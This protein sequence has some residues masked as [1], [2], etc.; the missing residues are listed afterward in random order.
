MQSKG[1]L[2]LLLGWIFFAVAAQAQNPP[3]GGPPPVPQSTVQAK[4]DFQNGVTGLMDVT[5]ATVSGYRPLKL[6]LYY[7][8]NDNKP[9]PAVVW[10]HG[11]GWAGGNPRIGVAVL[12]TSDKVLSTLAAR[13]YVTAAVSYRLSGE[14]KFPAAMQDV[15]AAIR[16]LRAN[17][18][19][20]HIDAQRI[21]V[22]G[23]SA[24]GHLAALAGTSCGVKELE[25][26]GG[27]AEQSS[28]VQAAIDFYG[29]TDF[30]MMDAQSPPNGIRHGV[31]DSPESKFLGCSLPQCP[32]QTIKLANP[33]TYIGNK[34]PPF[35]IM[36]G[37]ADVS[38]P[39]KQSQMLYEALK[40]KG[41]KAKLEMVP[42]VAH[43]FMGASEAQAKEIL[44]K[45]NEFLDETVGA[46]SGN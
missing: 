35:L 13:G 46:K 11:G 18:A 45:V 43:V 12:G 41:V 9:K 34:T 6:D 14:A 2:C 24:G 16:F 7:Q 3:Q 23:E 15:K 30:G 22:W 25:G 19:K 38:V 17:A 21:A 39:P 42:G 5:Y 28:C 20:Y 26:R 40:A 36:H 31:P 37:D 10:I 44:K 8:A 1:A 32:A 4:V 33:M 29:P 27:N